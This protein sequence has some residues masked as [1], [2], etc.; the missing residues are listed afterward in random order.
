MMMRKIRALSTKDSRIEI[1]GTG[2]KNE[3]FQ[4]RQKRF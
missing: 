1:P 2:D 3:L 4:R